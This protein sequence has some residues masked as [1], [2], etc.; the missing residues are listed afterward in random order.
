MG[1]TLWI[2]IVMSGGVSRS[3]SFQEFTTEQVCTYAQSKIQEGAGGRVNVDC[4][5]KG[6]N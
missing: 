2:L 4:V 5:P 1:T 6:G 3:V